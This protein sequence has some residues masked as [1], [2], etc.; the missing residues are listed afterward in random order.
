MH[1][2]SAA[3]LMAMIA[4]LSL[5]AMATIVTN[6]SSNTLAD[7]GTWSTSGNPTFTAYSDVAQMRS[8]WA[9][10]DDRSTSDKSNTLKYRSGGEWFD[11]E[12]LYI[13][14]DLTEDL[15]ELCG[16]EFALVTSFNGMDPEHSSRLLDVGGNYHDSPVI[17]F[18]L[19]AELGYDYALM[20]DTNDSKQ[21]C[22]GGESSFSATPSFY[23][24]ND[25]GW[26]NGAALPNG[27]GGN[28]WGASDWPPQPNPV[29]FYTNCASAISTFDAVSYRHLTRYDDGGE[30]LENGNQLADVSGENLDRS[31]WP[32]SRNWTWKGYVEFTEAIPFSC[33]TETD[34]GWWNPSAHI[35]MPCGND[36]IDVDYHVLPPTG[37]DTP[38]P[39]P[40][41]SLGLLLL[42][43]M[44]PLGL[45]AR[46][47]RM[48][49]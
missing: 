21:G 8:D 43:G 28:D 25:N 13:R 6:P 36:W 42:M 18:D 31:Y 9:T 44:V 37:S 27:F 45:V 17:A 33:S 1:C 20:L 2:R 29:D 49:A 7:W 11:L 40:E 35:S 4:T 34:D 46:R 38:S 22:Y 30:Y 26:R 10:E 23:A 15:A 14:L 39:T 24:V 32:Q 12:G 47:R 19:N 16:I 48:R 41:P 5:P 3:L